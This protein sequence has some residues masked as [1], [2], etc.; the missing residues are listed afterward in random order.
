TWIGEGDST[1]IKAG[2]RIA[3]MVISEV[4]RVNFL[5]VEPDELGNTERGDGGFGSTGRY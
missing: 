4:P 1:I 3:Q 2:E 5:E